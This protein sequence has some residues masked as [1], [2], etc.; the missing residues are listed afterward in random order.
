M[1]AAS[2]FGLLISKWENSALPHFCKSNENV[3]IDVRGGRKLG[4]RSRTLAQPSVCV[5]Q[6]GVDIVQACLLPICWHEKWQMIVQHIILSFEFRKLE[7]YEI[8]QAVYVFK[9]SNMSLPFCKRTS[10]WVHHWAS[11]RFTELSRFGCEEKARALFVYFN[12][13]HMN[14]RRAAIV[15][16]DYWESTLGGK[17]ALSRVFCQRLLKCIKQEYITSYVIRKV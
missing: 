1:L 15:N 17:M 12:L 13:T 2:R 4:G 14:Q 9:Q 11:V 7:L 6:G 16:C 3:G 5:R 10:V 8:V